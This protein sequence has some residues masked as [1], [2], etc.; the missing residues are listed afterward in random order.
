MYFTGKVFFDEGVYVAIAKYFASGGTNGFFEYIRPLFLPFILTPLQYLPIDPLITGRILGFLLTVVCILLIYYISRNHFDEDS[1]RWSSLL[2]AASSSV[3]FFGG[4]ILTDVLVFTLVLLSASFALRDKWFFA[5]CILGVSFLLKFPVL[6]LCLPIA[7]LIIVKHRYKF[8]IPS[9]YFGGGLILFILPYLIFNF[10]HY[11]GPIFERIFSPLMDASSILQNDTW[12]YEKA[13]LWKYSLF[14]LIIE[15]PVMISFIFSLRKIQQKE[16]QTMLFFMLC[17]TSFMFYFS[18]YV[19]RLDYRYML[20]VIPFLAIIGGI[21]LSKRIK[22]DWKAITLIV[23]APLIMV[24]IFLVIGTAKTTVD[25]STGDDLVFTNAGQALLKI[26]GKAELYPGPNLGHLYMQWYLNSSA[27]W[28]II[29]LEGY[30]CHKNDNYCKENLR[31]QISRLLTANRIFSCGKL[32]GEDVI[33][34]AK[35]PKETI[36]QEDCIKNIR[37]G[38]YLNISTKPYVR[39]HAA[40]I[41][42]EGQ[43]QN[44]EGLRTVIT[45]LKE[46]QISSVLVIVASN[47]SLDDTGKKFIAEL[48]DN[49]ELGVLPKEGINTSIFIKEFKNQTN[50]TITVIASTS[51]DWIGKSQEFPKTIESCVRG[52]WDQTIMTIPCKKIDLYTIQDWNSISLY[53]ASDLSA[54]FDALSNIDYQVG[55]D[56][57][58][59]ALNQNNMND[60]IKL[61]KYIGKGKK[62]VQD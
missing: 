28:L 47:T 52:A 40:V 13:S 49:I 29:D 15:L 39:L 19:A 37:G 27:E 18:W 33:I 5:G 35:H 14:L 36:T 1:A 41:T 17:A 50:K 30:P 10:F 24:C 46:Q 55:I 43:L 7:L 12:I 22:K 62:N 8:L 54:S 38:P 42:L 31:I 16:K 26:N 2:F 58:V 53:N 44:I 3:I 11:S 45:D 60:I 51:D 59:A 32:Y 9:L 25:I 21:G 57:P 4:T 20:S 23:A 56:I 34:L 6:L 48:P 61:I